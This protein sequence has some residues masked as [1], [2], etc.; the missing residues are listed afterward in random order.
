MVIDSTQLSVHTITELITDLFIDKQQ[1]AKQMLKLWS[2]IK[3]FLVSFFDLDGCKRLV[4]FLDTLPHEEKQAC[5][6]VFVDLGILDK[7]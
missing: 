6:D 4:E 3:E 7:K 5:E 1:Q 2:N